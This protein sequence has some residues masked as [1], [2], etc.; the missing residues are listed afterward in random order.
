MYF[1]QLTLQRLSVFEYNQKLK[2]DLKIEEIH[3]VLYL[4]LFKFFTFCLKLYS[5]LHSLKS[6]VRLI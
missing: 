2:I 5:N 4:I 3:P 6:K 1:V